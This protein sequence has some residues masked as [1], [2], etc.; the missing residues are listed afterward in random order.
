MSTQTAQTSKGATS[1]PTQE[2]ATH[3]QEKNAPLL[4]HLTVTEQINTQL[5]GAYFLPIRWSLIPCEMDLRRA[6]DEHAQTI[7]ARLRPHLRK[8]AKTRLMWWY[9]ELPHAW[10]LECIE[11][12][13]DRESGE[14]TEHGDTW[15]SFYLPKGLLCPRWLDRWKT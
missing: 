14:Y 10:L 2:K 9:E 15:A 6:L 12:W 8:K 4:S 11:T 5:R 7:E 1:P 3:A 13:P